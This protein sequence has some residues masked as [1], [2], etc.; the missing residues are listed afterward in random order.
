[1]LFVHDVHAVMGERELEF[2]DSVRTEYAPAVAADDHTRLFWY[3]NSTHGAGEAYKVV[4]ITAVR[5][6]A[7]WER[8]VERLRRGALRAWSGRADAMRYG[9]VSTLLV[10]SASSPLAE[11]DLAS[12]SAEPQEHALAVYRE[13][14]LAGPG[15]DAVLDAADASPTDA[16]AVL[17]P[18]GT[19]RPAVD[20]GPRRVVLYRVA[21]PDRWTPAFGLD[22]GWDD[23]PGSL[24]P[25]LPP[26]VSGSSRML[27]TSSWS[28]L[29]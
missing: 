21:E 5:D 14:T 20:P 6:G 22:A 24:T 26:A 29:P 2:E 16:D 23:W 1:V 7:A 28:P 3:L 9:L 25:T 13:D 11:L 17:T 18:V 4:T 27:R 8:H 15:L 12:V 19:F 10:G